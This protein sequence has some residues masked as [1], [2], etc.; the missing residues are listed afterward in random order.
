MP[1]SAA[2]APTPAATASSSASSSSSSPTTASSAPFPHRHARLPLVV[3]PIPLVLF[4]AAPRPLLPSPAAVP[5]RHLRLFDFLDRFAL[6]FADSLRE[7]HR[8]LLAGSTERVF[9]HLFA[10]HACV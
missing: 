10:D 9:G 8:F 6:S 3:I 5:L 7:E 2:T 1:S 4:V